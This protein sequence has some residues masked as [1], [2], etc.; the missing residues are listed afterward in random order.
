MLMY[1]KAIIR[2][3]ALL[4]LEEARKDRLI[5][6]QGGKNNEQKEQAS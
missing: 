5:N 2:L 1:T 3:L 4:F 6:E